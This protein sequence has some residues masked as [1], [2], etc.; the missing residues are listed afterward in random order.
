MFWDSSRRRLLAACSHR[1]LRCGP[2]VRCPAQKRRRKR[3]IAEQP[4]WRRPE[5]EFLPFSWA[6]RATKRHLAVTV[7]SRAA[8]RPA[9]HA[10]DDRHI[11]SR[12]RST[13]DRATLKSLC[14]PSSR[15]AA[16]RR[17]E[18][19]VWSLVSLVPKTNREA[20][21]TQKGRG[22]G[23]RTQAA[24]RLPLCPPGRPGLKQAGLGAPGAPWGCRPSR[25]AL[26]RTWELGP[27]QKV[28]LKVSSPAQAPLKGL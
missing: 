3:P 9:A 7:K 22:S 16:R 12:R 23:R 18:R 27:P 17:G 21:A 6:D 26:R 15:H 25:A 5:R 24:G 28:P 14:T 8:K 20:K 10:S 1:G 19:H 2:G 4:P 13:V 11:T